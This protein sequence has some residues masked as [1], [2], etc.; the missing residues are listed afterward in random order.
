[1]SDTEGLKADEIPSAT[2]WARTQLDYENTL[3]TFRAVPFIIRS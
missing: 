3:A 1:M 2:R